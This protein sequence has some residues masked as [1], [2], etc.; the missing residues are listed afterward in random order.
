[1]SYRLRTGVRDV[2]HV[3][4]LNW[5]TAPLNVTGTAGGAVTEPPG[6]MVALPSNTDVCRWFLLV[7]ERPLSP[8][9]M[10]ATDWAIINGACPELPG[11]EWESKPEFCPTL[12]HVVQPEI[13]L[14][15]TEGLNRTIMRAETGPLIHQTQLRTRQS[16][17]HRRG[18]RGSPERSRPNES[19]V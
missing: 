10:R 1:V 3:L 2:A 11:T 7:A 16:E 8:A 19:S 13:V 5:C 18:P 14:P 4:A 17:L 6:N 15:G 12:S 9:G